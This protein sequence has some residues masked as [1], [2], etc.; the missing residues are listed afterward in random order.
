MN[1]PSKLKYQAEYH[2]RI[3][4]VIDAIHSNIAE[5]L[6][7]EALAT[8]A[9]FSPYHF[10]RIFHAITGQTVQAFTLRLRLDLALRCMLHQTSSGLTEIA[11]AC[12]FG[13]SSNFSRVFKQ[14]FGCA[15]SRFNLAA[16]QAEH[17]QALQAHV[18]HAPHICKL[19]ELSDAHAFTVR[20]KRLPKRT[21]AYIRVVKPFLGSAVIDASQRLI[22]WAKAQGVA[23]NQWLGYMWE[24]PK[25]VSMDKC[26]YDVAVEISNFTARGEVGRYEFPPMQVA[27]IE[28]K[29]DIHLELR[30][31]TWLYTHWLPRSGFVPAHLPCFEAWNGLP[32]AHGEAHFEL[33]LQLPIVRM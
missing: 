2:A 20:I 11:L 18:A 29:G 27:E 16:L 23:Q 21:V 17:R 24:D 30:A 22:A 26:R 10:H 14:Q 7:L 5:P 9:G 32:F 12:G 3:N 31:L 28:I 4:R 6:R 13:S 19:P 1:A 25:V 33:R 15:P 8:C